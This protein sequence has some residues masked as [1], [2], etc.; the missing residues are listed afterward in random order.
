MRVLFIIDPIVQLNA[1]KD[2]SV[3]MMQGLQ[4]RGHQLAYTQVDDLVAA[5]CTAWTLAHEISLRDGVDLHQADWY[6]QGISTH[7][8][9]T[10]FDAVL[11]RKDPPFDIRYFYATH[12]LSLAESQGVPVFNSGQALRDTPEKLAILS[13]TDCIPETLV[14]SAAATIVDFVQ[15]QGDTVIKPLDG[16]GGR[17]ICRLRPDDSNLNAIIELV[18]EYGHMPVMLQRFIDRIDEGDKRVLIIDGEVVPYCLARIPKPGET[19]GNLAA[20]GRGV[21]QALSAR[22]HEIA[23]RVIETFAPQGLFLMGI[24]IIGDR[25]TEINVT[26]PTCFVEITEGTGWP[27]AET[28]AKALE[29]RVAAQGGRP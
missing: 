1:Y 5:Q 13:L 23:Q 29:Q 9:L 16:M 27:V 6:R 7:C 26:S 24:D 22:D 2:T 17:G 8:R 21:T 19:R 10:D 25:L 28:F 3:A 4:A 12:L 20:G 18:T 14:T 11:M 15:A